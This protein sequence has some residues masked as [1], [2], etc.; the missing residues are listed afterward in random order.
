MR[1]IEP[2]AITPGTPLLDHG[3]LTLDFLA[4]QYVLTDL[5]SDPTVLIGTNVPEDD[6]DLWEAGSYAAEDRVLF[7]HRIYEALTT[8]TDQP[9]IGVAADPPT[10]LLVSVANR[11]K[12]FDAMIS[13]ATVNPGII[14]Y[15]IEPGTTVTALALFGLSGTT[16]TVTMTDPVEGVVYDAA[17]PLQDNSSITDWY[18][19]YFDPIVPIDEMVLLD[20]PSFGGAIVDISI[21]AG[22]EMARCGEL[23]LGTQGDIGA[24]LFG[25]SVGILSYS[26]K[27][28]DQFGGYTITPR[29]FAKTVDF[30]V[31]VSTNRVRRIQKMLAAMRDK[32]IVYIGDPNRPETIVYGFFRSFNIVLQNPSSSDCSLEVE[33]LI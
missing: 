11:W 30:A 23:V 31:K 24:A 14:S 7:H 18:H 32:P 16:L 3:A 20:L 13:D 4:Q 26:Q 29:A 12:A 28:Q 5:D 21:I 33:G 15:S 8:T 10:W 25:T 17:L 1:T 27:T 22:S 6:Y 2:I 9:D 19:Y